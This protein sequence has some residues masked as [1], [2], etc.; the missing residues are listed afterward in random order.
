MTDPARDLPA[1]LA[2]LGAGLADLALEDPAPDLWP[3]ATVA[4][5]GIRLA[6]LARML[7]PDATHDEAD[8]APPLV[9]LVRGWLYEAETFGPEMIG[10]TP[11]LDYLEEHPTL[12]SA[13]D[14]L[15]AAARGLRELC[16]A[17]LTAPDY[18]PNPDRP[19]RPR[20]HFDGPALE[21]PGDEA[22]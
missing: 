16:P 15:A 19:Y 20:R 4:G 14:T 22:D 9:E 6:E 18:R 12:L 5:L 7:D 21:D 11:S 8:P 17:W 2:E 13:A 10:G 3:T 1:A